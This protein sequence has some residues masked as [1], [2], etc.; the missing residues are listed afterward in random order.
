MESVVTNKNLGKLGGIFLA[1]SFYLVELQASCTFLS[2]DY[3]TFFFL[4]V[5]FFFFFFF[6]FEAL[7]LQLFVFEIDYLKR[8]SVI[9][10]RRSCRT[11]HLE[12]PHLKVDITGVLK[13]KQ[14]KKTAT[15]KNIRLKLQK[16]WEHLHELYKKIMKAIAFYKNTNWSLLL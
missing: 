1:W 8:C 2:M 6:F 7:N 9:G 4:E 13:N 12:Y 5:L 15:N 10:K 14:A 11:F 16:F 3:T